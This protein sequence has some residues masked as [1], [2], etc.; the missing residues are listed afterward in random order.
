MDDSKQTGLAPVIEAYKKD[1]DIT[2]ILE[3]LRRSHEERLLNL[4]A[5]QRFAH[6]LRRAGRERTGGP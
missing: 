1:I 4:M 5:L 3:N 2:L 6:E